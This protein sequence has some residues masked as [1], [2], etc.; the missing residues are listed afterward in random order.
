MSSIENKTLY[1]DASGQ[2]LGRLASIVAKKLLEGYR[3]YVF[4]VEKAVVSGEKNRVIDGY[5]LI[6]KVKSHVNPEKGPKRPRSPVSIF[7]RAVRGMLPYDKPKGKEAYRRLRAYIGLPPDFSN[8]NLT[9]FQEADLSRLR[10]RYVT[11]EDI[12]RALGW[13]GVSK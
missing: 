6:L 13:R 7:K 3:I 9:R 11:L 4:N 5:K 2:I 12:S 10:G 8:V 1:I